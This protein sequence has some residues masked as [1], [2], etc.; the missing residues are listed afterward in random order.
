MILLQKATANVLYVQCD[1]ILTYATPYYYFL[2]T[3]E[4]TGV[5]YLVELSNTTSANKRVDIFNLTLPTDLDLDFGEYALKIYESET[6]GSGTLPNDALLLSDYAVKVEAT[7]TAN[8]E[9]EPTGTDK[10]YNG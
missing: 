6:T 3:H 4:Q 5:E 2:F 9:Y 8:S 7:F 10:V 1:D